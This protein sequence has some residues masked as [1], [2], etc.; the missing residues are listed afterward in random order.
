MRFAIYCSGSA[1]TILGYFRKYKTEVLKPVFVYYDGQQDQ[2]AEELTKETLATIYQPAASKVN[3]A[4][5]SNDLLQHLNFHSIDYCFC[6]GQRIL[7]GDLLHEYR[8]RIINFHPSVLP[9]FPGL[10]AIDQALSTDTK[11]LGNTAHFIDETIDGGAVI[12][13]TIIPRVAYTDYSSVLN[14]QHEMLNKLVAL[15]SSGRV[16]I[17]HGNIYIEADDSMQGYYYS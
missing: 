10:N 9:L 1:G 4:L 12:L 17:R 16:K 11:F 2:V 8:Y 6:F 14:L 13:Q 7:K 15:L 3:G 5:V